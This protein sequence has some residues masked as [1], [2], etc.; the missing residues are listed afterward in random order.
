M[1]YFFFHCDS[2]DIFMMF[3]RLILMSEGHIIYQ[4]MNAS[5]HQGFDFVNNQLSQFNF[6]SSIN[7]AP[8]L[9]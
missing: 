1:W 2:T 7:Q 8:Q 3:D 5:C 9:K 6:S 4:G